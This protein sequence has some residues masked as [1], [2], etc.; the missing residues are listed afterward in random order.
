MCVRGFAFPELSQ[1]ECAWRQLLAFVSWDSGSD[2]SLDWGARFCLDIAQAFVVVG[3][4]VRGVVGVAVK[5]TLLAA[6]PHLC[7]RRRRRLAFDDP[8]P[9]VEEREVVEH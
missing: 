2:L 9:P 7:W 3:I 4:H 5:L 8:S 6:K 1:S